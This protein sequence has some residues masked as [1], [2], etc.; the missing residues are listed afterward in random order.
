MEANT[1]RRRRNVRMAVV[2]TV[3]LAFASFGIGMRN[4]AGASA[5]VDTGE[6]AVG[7]GLAASVRPPLFGTPGRCEI[8]TYTPPTASEPK[9]GEL[10]VPLAGADTLVVLVHGGGGSGGSPSDTAVW[11]EAYNDLGVST[12]AV[13]YSLLTEEPGSDE[14]ALWPLPEQNVKAAVQFVTMNNTTIGADNVFMHGFSAG[15]R[16]AAVALTTANDPAFAG[17]E[18]WTDVSDEIDGAAL[19]YGYYDG[20]VFQH[21]AYF[22]SAEIPTSAI[23]MENGVT[24][25]GPALLV[26]GEGDFLVGDYQS[27]QF[28]TALAQAGG[29]AELILVPGEPSHG[30]DGYGADELT[31]AGAELVPVVG[32]FLRR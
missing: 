28:A 11:A 15:A 12:F 10:C 13:A 29:Y 9:A 18:L 2:V 7:D 5:A 30:F 20:M 16:L 4:A 32:D 17:P 26:H 19:F 25:S 31:A 8:V 3:L 21:D 6:R 1:G 14:P 27:A 22:G 24:A 23:P